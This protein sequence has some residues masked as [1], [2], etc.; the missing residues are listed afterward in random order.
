[1]LKT[2]FT[3]FQE[4]AATADIVPVYA[5]ILADMETPVSILRRFADD[6]NVFL[7]ESVEGGEKFGRYSF[8][9]L[10]PRGLF[11]IEGGQPHV[12]D[13]SG[14]RRLGYDGCPLNA[15]RDLFG[16]KRCAVEPGLPPITGG[17]VG[18]IGYEAV[19]L[20]EELPA[21]RPTQTPECAFMLTDEIIAFDNIRHTIKIIVS[22]HVG[23]HASPT[24]A[25]RSAAERIG[26]IL[27]RI[28]QPVPAGDP[29]AP[30][31]AAPL[32]S[33]MSRGDFCAMVERA[34]QYIR[35]GEIIQAVLSQKFTAELRVSPFLI[36]R[37]LRLVNPSPYMFFLKLGTTTLV[38]SSPETMVK[39]EN[40]R[41]SLRPIAGTKPRGR[42]ESEDRA[43][44][45]EMLK[46]EKER[47]EHLML[48]D[49]GRNDLGRTAAPGSVKVRT[50][51]SVERYSHVMHLVSDVDADLAG[52]YDAFDLLRTTFPAGTLSGAPK[53]RAMEIIAELEPEARGVYGGTVGYFSYNGNMDMAI[54]IRTVE[55]RDGILNIQAGAGIVY[56]SVPEKEY[57]ETLNKASALFRSIEL[58]AR[59]LQL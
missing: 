23:E 58:A 13:R 19:C 24:A 53:I 10:H 4:L 21:P 50:F 51:M 31:S 43:L 17:A 41:S 3:R 26:V 29:P 40:G 18:F 22:V 33:N 42:S 14:K 7:L 28:S 6:E 12:A 44:A 30:G 27:G 49:L 37:A 55:C 25:Y 16:R 2:T 5:E 15:L 45:D 20:F 36:Y 1:M 34:R 11:T 32:S 47:A 39:L 54:T 59:G 35:E 57:E 9:G 46:D 56:D 8:I 52:Q 38:G 48:V